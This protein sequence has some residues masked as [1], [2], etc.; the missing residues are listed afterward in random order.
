MSLVDNRT[1]CAVGYTEAADGLKIL[2]TNMSIDRQKL[3][4]LM[5]LPTLQAKLI[6]LKQNKIS[7][8][9]LYY[10][11]DYPAYMH[12]SSYEEIPETLIRAKVVRDKSDVL[13][14]LKPLFPNAQFS[15]IQV[16]PNLY[17]DK[18]YFY[19][20]GQ[21]ICYFTPQ[22]ESELTKDNIKMKDNFFIYEFKK[23][24]Y[25]LGKGYQ[26]H[27]R[28]QQL[29]RLTINLATGHAV[30][31]YSNIVEDK[32]YKYKFVFDT[33]LGRWVKD[34]RYSKSTVVE[35]YKEG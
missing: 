28:E 15:T 6:F 13:P 7:A 22:F 11:G 19:L 9:L 12:T 3:N 29:D 33:N 8:E 1:K 4:T 30:V 27:I 18:P 25:Y 10:K 20:N 24:I 16:A 14:I 35:G 2:S 21:F 31:D 5:T 26:R 23:D 32:L 34:E 17:Y